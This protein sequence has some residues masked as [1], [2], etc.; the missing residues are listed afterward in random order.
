MGTGMHQQILERP[1]LDQRHKRGRDFSTNDAVE[2]SSYALDMAKGSSEEMS[3]FSS[4]MPLQSDQPC[5]RA[6][7]PTSGLPTRSDA[8]RCPLF[9]MANNP[10]F[11]PSSSPHLSSS[12]SI[13]FSSS[14]SSMMR[15][16]I[17]FPSPSS[18]SSPLLTFQSVHANALQINFFT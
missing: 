8:V 10:V 5:L 12:S 9:I 17:P 18:L 13:S 4:S 6:N 14:N 16:D 3:S 2:T 1:L 11:D 15:V 7:V